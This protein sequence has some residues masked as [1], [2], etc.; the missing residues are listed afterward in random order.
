MKLTGITVLLFFVSLTLSCGKESESNI[1]SGAINSDPALNGQEQDTSG[2]EYICRYT[3]PGDSQVYKKT[4]TIPGNASERRDMEQI[5]AN[6]KKNC[7][8][9]R[10]IRPA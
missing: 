10:G 8:N 4:V 7:L 3:F 6:M 5:E 2:G 9:S 1:D